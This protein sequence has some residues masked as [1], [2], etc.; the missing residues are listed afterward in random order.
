MKFAR[1]R[2][3]P[4]DV[5]WREL[6]EEQR[7]WVI[8]GEGPWE[9]KVWY[10]AKRFFAWLET[11]AYKMHI[12]VL[13]SKY[14]SYTACPACGGARLKPEALLWRLGA[15]GDGQPGSTSTT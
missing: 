5:P 15:S 12:R 10:G 4:L 3:I 1:K 13:L 7:R 6:T 8:D 14:R 2:G 9:K 11:K